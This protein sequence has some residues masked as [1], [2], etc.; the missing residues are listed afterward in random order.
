MGDSKEPIVAAWES[1]KTRTII[2]SGQRDEAEWIMLK[3]KML[4]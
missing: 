1:A 3:F 4:F 2:L